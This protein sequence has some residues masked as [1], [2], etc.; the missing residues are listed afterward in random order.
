M[1]DELERI[2]GKLQAFI[3]DCHPAAEGLEIQGLRRVTGGLSREN[4]PFDARWSES[5]R[6]VQREL[7]MRRDPVGSV[8]ETDRR[9]EFG[10]LR[11]LGGSRIPCPRVDWLDADG[12]FMDRPS[13]VMQRF[14]GTNDHFVLEGGIS[15]LPLDARLSLARRYCETL[16]ELHLFDWRAA[17]V[18]DL[19]P[20]PG[21]DA[22]RAAI[23][24][25]E[26]SLWRQT[27]D[28]RPELVE[29]LCWLRDRAPESQAT[30]L[31]HGDFKPGNSLLDGA[32]LQVM[33]DWETVHL[34]DPIE[35]IG[36]VTNPLRRREHR[37]PGH[38]EPED[39]IAHYRDRTGFEVDP[40]EVHFWN[41]F[42]CL[43]LN[44][45][46]LTGVR[47]FREGRADRPW[48]DDGSLARLMFQ[49]IGAA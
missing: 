31:V 45:I 20:D 16:A 33:L 10:V 11:A 1:S 25:W 48:S 13:I 43:K 14:G 32:E 9:I 49:M 46:L 26:A 8:L 18:G 22:A 38:W 40:A 36:W 30:V 23:D 3:E 29:V 7:I 44:T 24:E 12:R 5:G 17:G 15:Q 6:P 35:D 4:W 28:P 47:S 19:L 37:I 21:R 39:L 34:G 2:R 41:V 27:D 42:A